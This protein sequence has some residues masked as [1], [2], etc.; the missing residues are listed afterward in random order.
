M[1][2]MD[3]HARLPEM[4]LRSSSSEDLGRSQRP[5]TIRFWT[6]FLRKADRSISS[7][8]CSCLCCRKQHSSGRVGDVA[9][10]RRP[11]PSWGRA[12]QS[13]FPEHSATTRDRAPGVDA[14][15]TRRSAKLRGAK[16][17]PKGQKRIQT[18]SLL[19]W[20]VELPTFVQAWHRES[21]ANEAQPL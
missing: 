11:L 8:L 7:G 19:M 21:G 5:S 13:R 1:Q 2:H 17:R 16:L 14:M 3:L 18:S 12:T 15:T 10:P 6:P 4:R 20:L 9:R